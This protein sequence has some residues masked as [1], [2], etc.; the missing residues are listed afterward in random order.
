M[1]EICA[2]FIVSLEISASRFK[3]E[4]K[5]SVWDLKGGIKS[6][7]SWTDFLAEQQILFFSL[8]NSRIPVSVTQIGLTIA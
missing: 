8:G 2:A 5:S 6:V 4:K 7:L 1:I 3:T